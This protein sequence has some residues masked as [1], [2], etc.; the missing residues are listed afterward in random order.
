MSSPRTNPTDAQRTNRHEGPPISLPLSEEIAAAFPPGNYRCE[1]DGM[2]VRE[3]E[4]GQLPALRFW[5]MVRAEGEQEFRSLQFELTLDAQAQKQV[6]LPMLERITADDDYFREELARHS[7]EGGGWSR[8]LDDLPL[9]NTALD[10][11]ASLSFEARIEK[12]RPTLVL[13]RADRG[14]RVTSSR[15]F[16]PG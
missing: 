4:T 9:V 3:R 12:D 13:G 11:L 16:Y 2:T 10:S 15:N 8:A 14:E 7:G 6:L 5:S 1:V